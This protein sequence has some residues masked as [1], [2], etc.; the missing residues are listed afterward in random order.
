MNKY[1]RNKI[2]KFTLYH[3]YTNVVQ[4]SRIY[5]I[6]FSKIFNLRFLYYNIY[7]N[8]Q[9]FTPQRK[10]CTHYYNNATTDV[11]CNVYGQCICDCPATNGYVKHD[12]G[13]TKVD[14]LTTISESENDP[15]QTV[16]SKDVPFFFASSF[17][18]MSGYR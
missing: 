10:T 9:T 7:I 14:G 2:E 8:C 11:D 15:A 13:C 12:G 5:I 6:D 18:V 4:C 17:L 3:S 1:R 16:S